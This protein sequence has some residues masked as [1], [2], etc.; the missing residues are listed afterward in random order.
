MAETGSARQGSNSAA[1]HY[2]DSFTTS[3]HSGPLDKAEMIS[4]AALHAWG[5]DRGQGRWSWVER[6]GVLRAPDVIL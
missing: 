3:L 2:M 1:N 5:T 6:G 4:S